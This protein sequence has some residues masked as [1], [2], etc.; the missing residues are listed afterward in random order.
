[1][2]SYK[3]FLESIHVLSFQPVMQHPKRILHAT[4]RHPALFATIRSIGM[5]FSL[6]CDVTG[7]PLPCDS[8][9]CVSQRTR[10]SVILCLVLRVYRY[11]L[12][13]LLPKPNKNLRLVS[14]PCWDNPGF[15]W[16]SMENRFA[17]LVLSCVCTNI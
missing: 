13:R 14:F 11:K 4:N 16:L 2:Y 12:H 6:T 8:F 15:Y 7:K 10:F 5:G 9:V 17:Y 1:M 3:S